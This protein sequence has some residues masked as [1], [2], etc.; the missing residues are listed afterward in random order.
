MAATKQKG[1]AAARRN[2]A[3]KT[4]AKTTANTIGHPGIGAYV[5]GLLISGKTTDQ[6]LRAVARQFPGANTSRAS[7]SWYRSR[8]NKETK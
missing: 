6:I 3:T 1:V 5:K 4:K 2:V 8:L 7:V